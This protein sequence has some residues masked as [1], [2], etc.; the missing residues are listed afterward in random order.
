MIAATEGPKALVMYRISSS[1]RGLTGESRP[2]VIA[3]RKPASVTIG[4][5]G[6]RFISAVRNIG[7]HITIR[8]AGVEP[9]RTLTQSQ[10]CQHFVP[11][12]LPSRFHLSPPL[13][14]R[15]LLLHAPRFQFL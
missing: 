13:A 6:Y 2:V 12:P 4:D 7:A 8:K 1:A 10:S 3:A 9:G 11:G 14:R 15:R 5:E